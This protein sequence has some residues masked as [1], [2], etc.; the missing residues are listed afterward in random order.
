MS[1]SN[2]ALL[3][4]QPPLRISKCPP[5]MPPWALLSCMAFPEGPGLLAHLLPRSQAP[6]TPIKAPPCGLL[7]CKQIPCAKGCRVQKQPLIPSR[8]R[9]NLEHP[10]DFPPPLAITPT[11]EVWELRPREKEAMGLVFTACF[12]GATNSVSSL[13]P[14][15]LKRHVIP[16]YR[17][18]H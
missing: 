15:S 10:M 13:L 14:A 9:I 8:Q 3:N 5:G 2:H 18:K 11:S 7:P 1:S 16:F 6:D 17:R 12:P 4:K